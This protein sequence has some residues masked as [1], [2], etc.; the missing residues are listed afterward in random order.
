MNVNTVWLH[1]QSV[2][3]SYL[4]QEGLFHFQSQTISNSKATDDIYLNT[5]EWDEIR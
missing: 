1:K 2:S 5:E 4:F 3:K